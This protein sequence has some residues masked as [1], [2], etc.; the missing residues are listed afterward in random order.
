MQNPMPSLERKKILLGVTGGI[1]AYKSALLLR[2]LQASGAVVRVVMTQAAQAFVTPLTFQALSGQRVF[3]EL[4]DWQQEASMPH[5][6]LARWPDLILVAPASAD[7]LARLSHGLADDLLSTLCLATTAPIAVAPAMNQQMWLNP[8]TRENCRRLA[9]RGM[10]IWGPTEGLQACGEIGPGRMLE[11]EELHQRVERLFTAGPLL[12]VQVLM[13]AGPTREPIDPVRYL[14]NRSSGKM[15]FALAE[16]LHCLGAEVCLVS[17]PVGLPT[18]AGVVR[19][20]VETAAEMHQAVMS[21]VE[22]CAIFVGVAAVADYRPENPATQ[23]LK[24]SADPLRLDLV[25]NPDIL[26]EVARLTHAPFTVGF[27]AETERLEAFA[28]SKRSLKGIDLIA[29]NLVGGEQGGFE[30]DENA[31]LLA[32]EGGREWLSMMP[33]QLLAHRLAE[34]IS[35]L[36]LTAVR[37]PDS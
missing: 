6:E 11:A 9:A 12:G 29:A 4:L 27:A 18:P 3:T 17:G 15:G 19:V 37:Q 8:A 25:A 24:R 21:R 36:Y 26:T 5:I 35:Q 22:D 32:W 34:R 33:K 10:Q 20:D 16:A 1:A 13:T 2:A 31:L 23:K 28:E 7:F 14:S 30:S